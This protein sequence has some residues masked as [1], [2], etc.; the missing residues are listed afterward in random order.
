MAKRETVKKEDENCLE[1]DWHE[2]L[3]LLSEFGNHHLA[4]LDMLN[5]F[6]ST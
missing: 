2:D 5:K 4:L 1:M 6:G 3:Q